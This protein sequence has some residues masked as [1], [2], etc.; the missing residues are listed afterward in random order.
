MLAML[1]RLGVIVS[2]RGAQVV[3]MSAG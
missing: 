2:G 3:G 1:E